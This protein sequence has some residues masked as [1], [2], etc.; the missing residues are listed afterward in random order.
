MAVLACA[1]AGARAQGRDNH[2]VERVRFRNIGVEQGLSQAS[3]VDIAQDRHGFIW[4]ATQDGLDRFDGYGFRVYKHDRGDPSSLA[5]NNVHRLLVDRRG[6]LWVGTTS[7]GLSRYDERLDRFD[8]FIP[9]ASR[10][11]A[12]GS[13]YVSA[14]LEDAAGTLWVATRNHGLQH[15]DEAHGTFVDS[16][17][18]NDALRRPN[19]LAAHAGGHLLVGT[20]SGLFECDPADGTLR[21]WTSRSGAHLAVR[22][23]VA[24]GT[25]EVW[26]TAI[27][28][29]LYRFGSDGEEIEHYDAQTSPSLDDTDLTGL[30]VDRH[31]AIWFGSE[32]AGLSRLNPRTR[33]LET[34]THAPEQPGSLAGNR[35]FS[36]FEDRDGQ[37][38]VGTW[39]NGISVFDPRA[40]GFVSVHT[41]GGGRSLPGASVLSVLADDDG[42]FW[43]STA[44]NGGLSHF[45]LEDGLL[46]HFVHDP[47]NPAS[48]AHNFVVSTLR[49]R[50]GSLWIATRGG[51]LDR[52]RPHASAF[53]HFQHDPADPRSI[54]SDSLLRLYFDD[55][56]TL[57]VGTTD[58]GVDALCDGCSAF[59][60]YAHVDGVDDSL[61]PG[62]V[63]AILPDGHGRLWLGT[64]RGG[65]ALLDPA[66]GR[67]RHFASDPRNPASLPANTVTDLHRDRR[68]E[69]WLGT[70]GGGL[71]HLLDL[72]PDGARFE[73][74][75]AH[76]GLAADAIGGLAEDAQGRIWM[77]TTVGIS[78]YDP[79]DR[80]I[81][82]VGADQ[83]ASASGYF[84]GAV[85]HGRDGRI[86]FGGA[87]EAT[88]FDPAQIPPLPVPEPVL[89]ELRLFNTP[90]LPRWRDADSPLEQ[91]PWSG[92]NVRLNH[93]QSM[94]SINYGAP[95]A[96]APAGLR[97][98]YRL[99]PHDAD[100]IETDAELRTAT[101]TRLPPGDYRFR[102][103]ARYPGQPWGEK[104]ATLSLTVLP[105]PWLSRAALAL[106]AVCA[107]ML[108]AIVWA[109][110]RRARRERDAVQE[111]VRQSE[112]RLKLALWGSG[113]ELW[114]I[115]LATG[116]MHR[117]NQLEHLAVTHEVSEHSLATYRPFV[118][119][120]DLERFERALGAHLSGRLPT[121][122]A[123]YR[124]QDTRHDWV[125]VLTR[126]R[127]VQ[128]DDT[129]RAQ[130][131]SG[132]T[133]DINALNQALAALRTLN[134]QLESRV[135]Q[136]TAA[137][138]DANLE[139]RSTLERL[140]LAQRQ[141]FEAEKLA[142]LGGLVAGIAHEI[143]TPLGIGVTAASHLQEEAQRISRMIGEGR[144]GSADLEEFQRTARESSDMILRNL[145][146]ADRLVKSFKQV[147]VDQSSEDRRV[148][149]LGVCLNEILTTLGPSLKK[150]AHRA[151][152]DCPAGLIIETAPGALYQIVTNLVMNS[153]THGFVEGEPGTIRIGVTLENRIVQIDYRDDGRG[154]DDAVRARIFEPF[155]TTRR[156]QGGSGLGMHIVY[157]LVSQV[158]HGHIDC[159]SAPGQG[160]RFVIRFGGEV[161]QQRS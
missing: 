79:R 149:D 31:G 4:V 104:E 115:D 67:V 123:S 60:H 124:T 78:R 46:E 58:N 112:E 90:V 74:I 3:G 110:A 89:T 54:A 145:Q 51:G 45:D 25:G 142:S 26:L 126:G 88:I 117:D 93:R 141:L 120:D 85:D 128:R 154:M 82:N 77:S 130:R 133:S 71:A 108:A 55:A 148:V 122:E 39:S 136:R 32:N 91:A 73:T 80:G 5:A 43:F 47:R 152:L 125:W 70:R 2:G 40:A 83:G 49:G 52:L 131:M 134:E 132:T 111:T 68:G 36:L 157:S 33:R 147:A 72:Y 159:E 116:R 143:N 106:Y 150:T 50:D 98:A 15:H 35:A 92:G 11:D 103:R 56:N 138:Q 127:V 109:R 10:A 37:I 84:I 96:F 95:S 8:N 155:F 119:P 153:L 41:G 30:H 160:T 61:A 69:L 76:A 75:D 105:A 66:S 24:T 94:L 63:Y 121:F 99:D 57:W 62:G 20:A 118:H 161:L 16:R 23:I 1:G 7:G 28:Q 65:L 86:V 42:T 100:W 97:F 59:R 129:G 107:A 18:R 22:T 17:C 53:E 44:E 34:F 113:S 156:G 102:V 19:A 146:R 135:E 27:K 13:E 48:L 144:L 114:D 158:L 29:G 101:Y 14:L 12:I 151:L 64:E 21:E 137:L 81:V 6:R 9:D 140:T 139:L 87:T 38:W